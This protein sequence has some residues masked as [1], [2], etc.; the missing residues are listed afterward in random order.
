MKKRSRASARALAVAPKHAGALYGRGN[1]LATLKRFEEAIASYDRALAN[2]PDNTDILNNR[3]KTLGSVNRLD[4]ALAELNRAI[5]IKPDHAEAFSNRGD[6]VTL[7][8]MARRP[9]ASTSR[10]RDARIAAVA[11]TPR[12]DPA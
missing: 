9:A 1:V 4:E 2:E 11:E 12:R 6:I 10:L 7:C 5:A 8:S 3:G